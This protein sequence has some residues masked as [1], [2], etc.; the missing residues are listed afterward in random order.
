M[1]DDAIFVEHPG[2]AEMGYIPYW[3]HCQLAQRD[4][5]IIRRLCWVIG[6]L[7]TVIIALFVAKNGG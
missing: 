1:T 5:K 3:R 7:S 4:R 6:I 2:G